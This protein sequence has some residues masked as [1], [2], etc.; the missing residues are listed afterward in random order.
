MTGPQTQSPRGWRPILKRSSRRLLAFAVLA[1]HGVIG[2]GATPAH[3]FLINGRW[4]FTATDGSTDPLGNP[5]TLT[6]SIVPDGTSIRSRNFVPSTLVSF[7][8]SLWNVQGGG[9][10]YQQRPWFELVEGS[11]NRWSEVSGIVFEYEPFDDGLSGRAHGLWSGLTG[12]RGDIRLGGAFIDGPSNTLGQAGLIPDGDIVLDTGD[13]GHFGDPGPD[14]SYR[15]FRNTLTHEVGHSLGL[16]HLISPN[17]PF[18][19]ESGFQGGFDGPQYDDVRGAHHLYG[20]ALERGGGNNTAASASDLGVLNVGASALFG[21]DGDSGIVLTGD[22]GNFLSISN[23]S[24]VD[25]LQFTLSEPAVLDVE[26]TPVGPTYN[27]FLFGVGV[28]D[29]VTTAQNDLSLELYES[30]PGGLTL[31]VASNSGGVGFVESVSGVEAPAGDYVVKVAGDT[32]AVQLYTLA[33]NAVAAPEPRLGDFNDDGVVD[34]ADYT[35]WRDNL[36]QPDDSTLLFRGDGSAG[37]DDG[38]YQVWRQSFGLSYEAV[39]ASSATPE[40]SAAGAL[41][42]GVLVGVGGRRRTYAKA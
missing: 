1:F 28:V 7:F 2:S 29:V 3:G 37:V 4:D 12:V 13:A 30:G 25:Y 18:L 35:V 19:M 33:L 15:N 23:A 9:T 17:S 11:F 24:D 36:G 6:W 31:I 26:L 34:A 16:G 39:A 22:Q 10:D 20:D 27:E 8:D 14:N 40:P 41:L 32:D 42:A 5:V 38:D 21:A